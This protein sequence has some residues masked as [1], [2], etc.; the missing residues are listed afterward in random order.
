MSTPSLVRVLFFCLEPGL[1]HA[2]IPWIRRDGETLELTE[3]VLVLEGLFGSNITEEGTPID[4]ASVM[5]NCDYQYSEMLHQHA[6]YAMSLLYID[7]W[8]LGVRLDCRCRLK[9]FDCLNFPIEFELTNQ[10][11]LLREL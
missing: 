8:A 6:T 11:A 1:S 7:G 2:P 5:T 9:R 3:M 4:P 10:R